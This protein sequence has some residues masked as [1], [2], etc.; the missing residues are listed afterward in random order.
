G[1]EQVELEKPLEAVKNEGA[2]V[3]LISLEEGEIQAF[4]HLDHG[5]KIKVDKAVADVDV[6]DY[7]ALVVPGGVA[8]PDF[9]RMDEDAVNFVRGFAEAGKPAGV[10]CHGPWMLVESGVV[11]GMTVTSWP[12]LRTDIQ[13]AGGKWVDEEV[14]VDR[15]IV[16]SRKPDDIPAFNAKIVEEFAEGKHEELAAAASGTSRGS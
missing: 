7:D 12:S 9:M 15:G 5:D 6:S 1:V 10:I 3:D 14:V 11:E 16:T 13:N 4:N 8:N 2:D